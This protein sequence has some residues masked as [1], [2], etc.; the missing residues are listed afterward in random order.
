MSFDPTPSHAKD[1]DSFHHTLLPLD[2]RY[3]SPPTATALTTFYA[4]DN[5]AAQIDKASK[6]LRR[7][8]DTLYKQQYLTLLRPHAESFLVFY[9]QELHP[10]LVE[11]WVGANKV[12]G[13]LLARVSRMLSVVTERLRMYEMLGS[14]DGAVVGLVETGWGNMVRE[15]RALVEVK[16][17][18]ES[19]DVCLARGQHVV[20]FVTHGRFLSS[21]LAAQVLLFVESGGVFGDAQLITGIEEAT[22]RYVKRWGKG[23]E[24]R[25]VDDPE[26]SVEGRKGKREGGK[27]KRVSTRA[28]GGESLVVYMKFYKAEEEGEEEEVVE[29]GAGGEISLGEEW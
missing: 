28:P 19:V 14:L 23:K 3:I 24:G 16:A 26:D 7:I 8:I 18:V 21:G 13:I 15:C 25:V 17:G 4:A 6:T 1:F 20:E 12:G 27:K 11:E 2:P 22:R 9:V 10:Y 29:R 5:S